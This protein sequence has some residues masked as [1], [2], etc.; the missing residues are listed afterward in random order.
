[1]L[2]AA[3]AVDPPGWMS[4]PI[5][6]LGPGRGGRSETGDRRGDCRVRLATTTKSACAPPPGGFSRPSLAPAAPRSL[7]LLRQGALDC[8]PTGFGEGQM[9]PLR[10]RFESLPFGRR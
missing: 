2:T 7:L 8:P 5:P 4:P 3:P 6:L 1:M 10:Q 9:I